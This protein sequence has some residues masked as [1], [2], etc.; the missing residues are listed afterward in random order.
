MKGTYFVSGID[1]NVG[2]SVMTG[3]LAKHL[4]DQGIS[5]ITQK[6]IQTGNIGSSEDIELHRK[7]M[8]LPMTED[9]LSGLTA[10]C[11]R[12]Y[13][14]SPHL[15]AR[16]DHKPIDMEAIHRATLELEK[17]YDV[18]LLEGAGGLMVP[19]TEDF[20]TIDYICKY[21]YP[22]IFVTSGRLGSLNQTLL[23]L[24][25]IKRRNI[26]LYQLIYNLYPRTDAIIEQESLDYLRNLL[27]KDFPKTELLVVDEVPFL[28]E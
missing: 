27:A 15:A 16:I 19:I 13:P 21:N 22:L 23:N 4:K 10:P 28:M 6:M 3:V 1:T 2:K 8:Q 18:V 7:I 20:L 11:I 25:A 24:E 26:P 9:D 17:K 14:C 12:S 5:I